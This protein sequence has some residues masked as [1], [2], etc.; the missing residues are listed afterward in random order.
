MRILKNTSKKSNEIFHLKKKKYYNLVSFVT[1][2]R[3]NIL[4]KLL[5]CLDNLNFTAKV[6]YIYIKNKH[7]VLIKR[8][9]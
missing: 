2:S 5:K 6:R 3:E 9:L 7:S 8:I 4:I 1:R